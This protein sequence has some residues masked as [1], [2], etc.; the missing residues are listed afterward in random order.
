MVPWRDDVL[1][2]HCEGQRGGVLSDSDYPPIQDPSSLA[3]ITKQLDQKR[4]MPF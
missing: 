2:R 4:I 1:A 3:S